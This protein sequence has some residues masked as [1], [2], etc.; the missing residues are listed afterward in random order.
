MSSGLFQQPSAKPV[1][2]LDIPPEEVLGFDEE[3]WMR[4]VSPPLTAVRQPVEAMALAA[5]ARL[6]ARIGGDTSPPHEVRLACTLE[7]RD[8]SAPAV[9]PAEVAALRR[10]AQQ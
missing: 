8:S 9:R 3:E 2:P 1:P 10:W 6:M 4:V 5:W 7:V